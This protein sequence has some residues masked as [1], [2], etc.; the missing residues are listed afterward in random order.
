MKEV[1]R[2]TLQAIDCQPDELCQRIDATDNQGSPEIGPELLGLLQD[3][4]GRL[5][6]CTQ[7]KRNKRQKALYHNAS[8]SAA[9]DSQSAFCV[10]IVGNAPFAFDRCPKRI[11][12]L[13]WLDAYCFSE[14]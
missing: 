4:D 2:T 11:E 6:H 12:R 5:S 9:Y 8:V 1:E 14:S 10:Q 13:S 3:L 7:G